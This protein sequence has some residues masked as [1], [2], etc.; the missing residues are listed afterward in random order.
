MAKKK[1]TTEGRI[2]AVESALS[3]TEQFIES[4][5]KIITYVIGGLIVIVLLYFGYRKF[6]HLPKE[7][8][9]QEAMYKAENYFESDSLDLAL[10]GD[11]ESYGFLDIIEDY[12]STDAGNLARYYAGICYLEKG[13]F[14]TA[15]D[16]L[17]DFSS[18][19][20]I[21]SGMALGAIGDAYMELGEID[22]ATS[23]YIRAA[24]N[25][26]NEMVTPTFLMK[27]GWAYEINKE[28]KDALNV[29]EKIKQDYPRSR[30]AREID[31]YIARA[32][33]ELGDI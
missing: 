19:D 4:N 9:A 15:I 5:Q 6:V 18:S 26:E 21:V 27:A 20:M 31:K 16:Y 33:A 12:G 17:K 28:Y 29:Y 13:E 8:A 24:E 11:G 23:Y 32:K 25:N 2:E 10:M 1:D 7:K 3:K 14:E 30:E 22:K